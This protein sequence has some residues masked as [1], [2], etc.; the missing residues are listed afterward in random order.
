M[1]A[2]LA[3]IRKTT[4]L[5]ARRV[6]NNKLLDRAADSIGIFVKTA[7]MPSYIIGGYREMG[8]D[9]IWANVPYAK[10]RQSDN[11]RAF[12]LLSA[13]EISKFN[14]EFKYPKAHYLNLRG[15][16]LS[17][18]K[19]GGVNLTGADLRDSFF[20]GTD[21]AGANL[22]WADLLGANLGRADLSKAKLLGAVLSSA[23]LEGADLTGADLRGTSFKGATAVKADFTGAQFNDKTDFAGAKVLFAKGLSEAIIKKFNLLVSPDIL[24][25][26]TL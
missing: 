11:I 26:L 19:L 1:E 25:G 9:G 13:G 24:E 17:F 23:K 5:A 16:D 2:R 20:I 8:K 15:A 21:L 10:E 22:A 12:S 3:L 14:E 18:R 4:L 6:A 7:I